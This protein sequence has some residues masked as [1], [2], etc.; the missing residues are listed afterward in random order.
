[1]L[2]DN[3]VNKN[4]LQIAEITPTDEPIPSSEK[5]KQMIAKMKEEQMKLTSNAK[6]TGLLP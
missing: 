3:V 2:F 5:V 6:H 4:G 1:M